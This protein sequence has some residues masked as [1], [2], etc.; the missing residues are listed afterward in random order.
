VFHIL[1]V[2]P[3][4]SPA[5]D[6]WPTPPL[7]YCCP[8]IDYVNDAHSQGKRI[9]IEGAN[10]T[11]L[12]IDFGTYPFV[13]SSNPSIGGIVCGLG[14][15]PAK[16]DAIVGVVSVYGGRGGFSNLVLYGWCGVWGGGGG[17]GV[18]LEGGRG[19]G[20]SN[21]SIGGIVCGLGLAPAKF[22]AIVGV[23]SPWGEGGCNVSLGGDATAAAT[24]ALEASCA[25]L[26]WHLPNSTP[27]LAW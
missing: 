9:L 17:K 24:P 19:T 23:V 25:V 4:L 21:P 18:T 15:A 27:L 26:G 10:A 12:D 22:D 11:M 6:L 20:S 14:L 2:H 16:F 3:Y 7:P 5:P 1:L 13:T 8:Q